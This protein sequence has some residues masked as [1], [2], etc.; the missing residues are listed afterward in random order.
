[1]VLESASACLHVYH[2]NRKV[3]K[4]R[5][6]QGCLQ[7]C[8]CA[9]MSRK[10]N[11]A[12]VSNDAEYAQRIFARLQAVP[13]PLLEGVYMEESDDVLQLLCTPSQLR[14]DI[15]CWI[16]CRIDPHFGNLKE[17]ASRIRDPHLL[18]NGMAVLGQDLMLCKGDSLDLIKGDASC[19]R[20]LQFLDQLLD[21]VSD[22]SVSAARDVEMLLQTLFA[23]EN[24]PHL[25]QMFSPSLDPSLSN[26]LTLSKAPKSTKPRGD[27]AESVDALIQSTRS[28][29]EELRSECEFLTTNE[30]ASDGAFTPR[31]LHVA[32]CDLRQLMTTFCHVYETD[33]RDCC[34]REMPGFSADTQVF[35]RVYEL[36]QACSTELEMLNEVSNTS[37]TVKEEVSQLQANLFCGSQG[38]KNTLSDQLHKLTT[39]YED[40]FSCLP[41]SVEPK[42]KK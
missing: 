5:G 34:A 31:A 21:V 33:L 4:W 16:C 22:C 25:T 27:D 6:A 32:L 9:A 37:A 29:L 40:F 17:K 35:Q 20:Q 42:M 36:L 30:E 18:A 41:S 3:E 28:M 38:K 12:A 10:K 8:A 15:L 1:M 23:T 19:H 24:L 14:T 11:M 13:C 2:T 39:R 26:I 7:Q